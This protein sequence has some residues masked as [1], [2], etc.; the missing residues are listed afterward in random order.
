MTEIMAVVTDFFAGLEPREKLII[1]VGVAIL[2]MTLVVLMLLPRWEAYSDLKSQRETLQSDMIWLQENRDV[3]A[4]LANNCSKVPQT[5]DKIE[6]EL[7][8]LARRNQ[9]EIVSTTE[10]ESLISVVA[11][12]SKSN[13]FLKLMH[14]IACHGYMLGQV[15]FDVEKD[16]LTK[17]KAT[18]EVERVN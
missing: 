10:K 16:D 11:S 2:A 5:A 17:I 18:F 3:V 1:K 13:H 4:E 9:L 7:S 12:G 15:T 6:A 14:Q 8:Q